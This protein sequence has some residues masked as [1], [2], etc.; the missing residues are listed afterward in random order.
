MDLMPERGRQ[1]PLVVLCGPTASGKTALAMDLAERLPVE[2]ISADSRQ[3]YR[4]MDIGTA[5]P[6]PE[7]QAR[8]PHH[9]IDV[10]TPD[11][12]FSAADFCRL[13]TAALTGIAG[14]GRLPLVV[15]GTGLYIQSLVDGLADVPGRDDVFR[16]EMLALEAREGEGALHRRL[17]AVDPALAARLAPRDRVR[18]LRGLEVQ[19]L[20]GRR[21]SD[22][23]A[24][25]ARARTS[26]RALYIGLR[27]PRNELYERI[28]TRTGRMFEAGLVAEVQA[29]LAAGYA[30]G[31]KALQTIGYRECIQYLQGQHSLQEARDAVQIATRRYAKRQMTWFGKVKSIIW[32][33]SLGE[34]AKVM[35][36][37]EQF[38]N[39]S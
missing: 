23:Q 20:S 17:E 33:D 28:D 21:L 5:K 25:H 12:A 13:G 14:S 22:L 16:R 1:P 2:I 34:F 36:L 11:Q 8:V 27:W 26:L 3:V 39:V 4:G 30:P 38:F 6:S 15:G 32:L 19:H 9:L 35:T 7:E 37:I 31:S 24:Q 29:L 18:I 10:V